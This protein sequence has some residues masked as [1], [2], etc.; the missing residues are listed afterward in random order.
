V[1]QVGHEEELL[2]DTQSTKYKK[3]DNSISIAKCKT[4]AK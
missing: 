2:Q 1:R 4:M 3:A